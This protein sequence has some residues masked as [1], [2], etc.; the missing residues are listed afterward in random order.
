MS[1]SAELNP[2]PLRVSPLIKFSRWTLLTVG[3]LYGAYFQRKFSNIENARRE[4]E[5]RERPE[6]EAREAIERAKR[7]EAENKML[8]D[9]MK[10]Q[11]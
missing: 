8:D 9:L 11:K 4:K 7:I 2:R 1:S 5:E 6:R 3:I 10:P